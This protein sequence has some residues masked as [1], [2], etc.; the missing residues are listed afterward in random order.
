[1]FELFFFSLAKLYAYARQRALNFIKPILI[2]FVLDDYYCTFLCTK[3][4]SF[5]TSSKLTEIFQKYE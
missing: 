3:Y 2:F 5:I 4:K 1:M